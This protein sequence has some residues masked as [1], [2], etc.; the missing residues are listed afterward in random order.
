MATPQLRAK[1]LRVHDP[2]NSRTLNLEKFRHTYLDMLFCCAAKQ[3]TQQPRCA[4]HQQQQP[5]NT[6]L[7]SGRTLNN[8][9]SINLP[10]SFDNPP[11]TTDS[12]QGT[13]WLLRHV[14]VGMRTNFNCFPN[15]ENGR[16]TDM[17]RL[18]VVSVAIYHKHNK[19]FNM[20]QAHEKHNDSGSPIADV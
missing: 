13:E 14:C 12:R 1:S 3:Y 11:P 20:T 4:T 18:L 5:P 19:T 7:V 9:V 6:F 8:A 15:M 17:R 2:C 16:Y 10:R